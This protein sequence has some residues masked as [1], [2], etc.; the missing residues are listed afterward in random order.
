MKSFFR[1]FARRHILANLITIMIILLGLTTYMKINRSQMPKVDLGEMVIFT[2]YPGASPED[3][4]LNV[5]NKL[6][7]ELQ[8]VTGI[9]RFTSVSMEN[10][11]TIDVVIK[12]DAADI[13][14]VKKE[15]REAVGRVTD[16]PPEVTDSPLINDIKTSI[17]PIIE[18]GITGDIPYPKLRE[19]ARRFEKKLKEIP[20]V[21]SVKRYG[22]RAREIQVEV[23]PKKVQKYQIPMREIILAIQTRNIQATGGSMESYTSE[24]NVVTL[25][26]FRHPLEVGEVIV[27]SSFDGPLIKVKDLAIV[28]DDFEDERIFPRLNGKK[29][30]SFL[31]T[32]SETGDIIKTVDAIRKLAEEE[33]KNLSGKVDFLYA[34][35]MSKYVRNMFSAVLMNCLIGLVLVVLVLMIFLDLRTAF[36]VAMGIPLSLLGVI[37]LLPFFDVDLDI[38][39]LSSMI[40]VIGIIVDD[41]II[42]SENIYHRKELGDTPLDAAV[43]GIHGVFLPVL[44]TVLTTFLVFLPM[45]FMKGMLGKFIYV[46]P[47]TISL[48]LFVSLAEVM[49]ILPAHLLPGL[50]RHSGKKSKPPAG[51]WFNPVKRWFRKVSY[52]TLKIRY[53][54]VL[55]AIVI[56]ILTLNYA[57]KYMDFILF[58]SKGADAFYITVELPIGSSLKATSDKVRMIEDVIAR[59]PKGEV[60][61][62]LVRIGSVFEFFDSERENGA[63]FAVNLTPHST[64]TR[65]ADQIVEGL[66]KKTDQFKG[67]KK[68]VYVVETGGPPTGKPVTIRIVGTDDLLRK[69]LADSVAPFLAAIEGVKDIERDDKPGK[70]Q[71]EI[72]VN[73]QKLARLGL[74]VSDIAQNVRIAYDGQVVTSVRYGDEDVDFRVQLQKKFRKSLKYL[75]ELTIPNRQGRL[76]PLQEVARFKTGHGPSNFRH[77][78][79]VRT[80]T[81]TADVLQE[82]TTPLKVMQVVLDHYNLESDYPGMRFVVGGEAQ[83]S[84][85]AMTELMTTFIVALLGVY[86]LLILLF[87]SVSKPLL[88][89]I[90]VPFGIVGVII[91]FALHGEPLTFM[92]M[93]GIIGLAGV[94]V[95]DSLVLVNHLKELRHA[96]PEKDMLKI[97]AQGTADRLRAI[98]LTTLST[99]VGLLPLAYG[100]GGEVVWMAPLALALGYGLLFATPITLIL[101]PSL[102]L[103]GIDIRRIF[104]GKRK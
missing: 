94:V 27:R 80:I 41:A 18:V 69:K 49:V 88:V 6:E 83:E 25:A 72:K 99:V 38:I 77:Y 10:I 29:A 15:I 47:L 97:V 102:Y 23:S 54:N 28:K 61:S 65:T 13:E 76:I 51:N 62:Y 57:A 43:N 34:N 48:A 90:A 104:R 58:P 92:G 8:G 100:L 36:W 91:A 67:F 5:T 1:F 96:N 73:F 81:I 22:Y 71:V 85:E 93:T 82:K 4:E 98:T 66:R 45:L 56:M 14:D 31:V 19:H 60:E 24:K 63:T 89:I 52:Y 44:T 39:T 20:G 74:T 30:I 50:H 86:F 3:V 21:A 7:E 16:F 42:I 11:S 87:N 2:H 26:Q 64:R 84:E 79:N 95:N 33:K 32:K 35:D 40:I 17:F 78:N 46:I 75:K 53:L 55:V 68:I 37:F 12:P 59:L 101:V 70:N 9:K 103:I